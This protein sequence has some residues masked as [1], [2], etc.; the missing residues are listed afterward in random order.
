MFTGETLRF[1][2]GFSANDTIFSGIWEQKNE[3]GN[4]V[5]LMDIKL[6]RNQSV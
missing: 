6:A 5:H 2:G 3:A 4:W 1:T